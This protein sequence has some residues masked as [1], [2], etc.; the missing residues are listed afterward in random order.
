MSV[1]LCLV[2]VK[3][4]NMAV[5][6]ETNMLMNWES[7]LPFLSDS[8]C[9]C[10]YDEK[11]LSHVK[12]KRKGYTFFSI[13]HG[14]ERRKEEGKALKGSSSDKFN[15]RHLQE[16][17]LK[18]KLSSLTFATSMKDNTVQVSERLK[19]CLLR[20]KTSNRAQFYFQ[21]SFCKK[22]ISLW[23][24]KPWFREYCTCLWPA[25]RSHNAKANTI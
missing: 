1:F 13:S 8:E 17:C 11:K 10:H 5:C 25:W 15:M 9:E 20:I 12:H 2:S 14:K 19:V 4:F 23:I 3:N 6:P 16:I 24:K 18:K 7:R 21:T 22:I